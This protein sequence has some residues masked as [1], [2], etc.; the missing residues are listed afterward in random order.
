MQSDQYKIHSHIRSRSFE[1]T[2]SN[3]AVLA[4]VFL[5]AQLEIVVGS[6]LIF[7]W[8]LFAWDRDTL[9]KNKKEKGI[10]VIVI[11]L[12]SWLWAFKKKKC[13]YVTVEHTAS[14]QL[15]CVEGDDWYDIRGYGDID[16]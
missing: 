13:H 12:K 9:F 15:N 14:F 4:T 5:F 8:T 10:T 3:A 11:L 2:K 16:K 7:F 6:P 1:V